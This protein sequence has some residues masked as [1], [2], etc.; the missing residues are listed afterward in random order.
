MS[1]YL[2]GD[3]VVIK[4]CYLWNANSHVSLE[5]NCFINSSLTP[6][7][8]QGCCVCWW[9]GTLP[10]C[11]FSVTDVLLHLIV[12]RANP[13]TTWFSCWY[14]I[15]TLL[16]FWVGCWKVF[17]F[18]K[19]DEIRFIATICKES[20]LWECSVQHFHHGFCC[21]GCNDTGTIT[22]PATK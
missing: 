14:L 10:Y 17:P 19:L 13:E 22:L 20:I 5:I 11:V 15:S 18:S 2:W 1:S 6:L 12:H 7:L 16:Q 8:Q 3:R 4:P 9:A 21:V